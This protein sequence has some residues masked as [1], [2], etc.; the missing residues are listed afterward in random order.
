M[1]IVHNTLSSTLL[2]NFFSE[3]HKMYIYININLV[4]TTLKILKHY[5]GK[6]IYRNVKLLMLKY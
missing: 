5:Q 4:K 6:G 1:V 2:L 3:R